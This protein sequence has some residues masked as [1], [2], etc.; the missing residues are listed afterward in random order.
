MP[1]SMPMG[2]QEHPSP[3]KAQKGKS[4]SSKGSSGNS[5]SVDLVALGKKSRQPIYKSFQRFPLPEIPPPEEREIPQGGET[6]MNDQCDQTEQSQSDLA[7]S[8]G[9]DEDRHPP[10]DEFAP[11]YEVDD[12]EGEVV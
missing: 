1:K 6:Q 5:S 11:D 4:P 2:N 10:Q 7:Q 3:G 9:A 12:E 8:S